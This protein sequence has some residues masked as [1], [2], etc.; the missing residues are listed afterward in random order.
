MV[1][2]AT[3]D[4]TGVTLKEKAVDNTAA[5]VL[6]AVMPLGAA[7]KAAKV[8]LAALNDGINAAMLHS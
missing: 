7:T 5:M 3:L 2:T 4:L 8:V 6:M 1:P